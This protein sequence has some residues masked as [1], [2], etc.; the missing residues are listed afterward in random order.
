MQS[1]V[2]VGRNSQD[3]AGAKARGKAASM[4]ARMLWELSTNQWLLSVSFACALG[5][6]CGFIA[7]RIM[8]FAGFGIIGNWLMLTTGSFAGLYVYNL[9]GLRFEW[10][11]LLAFGAAVAG[12]TAMLVSFASMKAMTNT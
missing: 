1:H 11:P 5:F 8:G 3:L 7:D 10:H 6:L 9:A 4:E 12:A 2:A